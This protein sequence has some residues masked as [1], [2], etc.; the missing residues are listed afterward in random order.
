MHLQGWGRNLEN[1]KLQLKKTTGTFHGKYPVP[2]LG[3]GSGYCRTTR[4]PIQQELALGTVIPWKRSFDSMP[5]S[6]VGAFKIGSL[7]QQ[8]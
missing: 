7:G 2:R 6:F 8:P 5:R 1:Q 3:S 4:F